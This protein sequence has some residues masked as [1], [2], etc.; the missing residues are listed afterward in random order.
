MCSLCLQPCRLHLLWCLC[1]TCLQAGGSLCY[2]SPSAFW[3]SSSFKWN[4]WHESLILI[5]TS[6]PQQS[7]QMLCRLQ[8]VVL[9]VYFLWSEWYKVLLPFS[10][11]V[12]ILGPSHH[13]P[14]SRCALTPADIYRTPLYDLRIDQKG[15]YSFY[16]WLRFFFLFLLYISLY[17]VCEFSP[18]T[19]L[20]RV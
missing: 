16:Y 20:F 7:E 15:T 12:F 6:V 5:F 3:H 19:A 14:L 17:L 2:V 8:N 13:V 4:V 1:S 10:R 11:R 9:V 18:A